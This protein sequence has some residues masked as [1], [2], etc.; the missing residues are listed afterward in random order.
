MSGAVGCFFFFFFFSFFVSVLFLFYPAF[1]FFLF[2]PL[3]FFFWVDFFFFVFSPEFDIDS[4]YFS[5]FPLTLSPERLV[6]NV[7]RFYSNLLTTPVTVLV[8]D[9]VGPPV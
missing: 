5:L 9:I 3:F 1:F 7:G 8:M 2:F 4:A 6:A